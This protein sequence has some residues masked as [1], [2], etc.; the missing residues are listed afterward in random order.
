MTTRTERRPQFPRLAERLGGV[1]GIQIL[2]AMDLRP[3]RQ[4]NDMLESEIGVSA[5]PA[6][7]PSSSCLSQYAPS[8]GGGPGVWSTS[9]FSWGLTP[10]AWILSIDHQTPS[11]TLPTPFVCRLSRQPIDMWWVR[12][13]DSPYPSGRVK[14]ECDVPR[15]TITNYINSALLVCECKQLILWMFCHSKH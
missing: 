15:T 3:M 13:C 5:P 2:F 11:V 6:L 8:L 7:G 1:L 4:N 12:Y 10:K 14:G 9:S